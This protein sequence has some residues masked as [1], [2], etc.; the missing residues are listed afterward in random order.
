MFRLVASQQ[1]VTGKGKAK[2][3]EL[4]TRLTDMRHVISSLMERL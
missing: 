2:M 1:P 4:T 3:E